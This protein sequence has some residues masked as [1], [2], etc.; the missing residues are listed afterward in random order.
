MWPGCVEQWLS[1]LALWCGSL[2]PRLWPSAQR[3]SS[4]RRATFPDKQSPKNGRG[5]GEAVHTLVLLTSP[6]RPRSGVRLVL[7]IPRVPL[8]KESRS[9]GKEVPH[10]L[11]LGE[12]CV[13]RGSWKWFPASEGK[14]ARLEK[15]D[16]GQAGE[17]GRG[18]S[19]TQGPAGGKCAG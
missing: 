12:V 15:M 18:K 10:S 8:H 11:A 14:W 3:W 16:R 13:G 17:M 9:Q 4:E 6:C 19:A 2:A 7:C 5:M 1:D